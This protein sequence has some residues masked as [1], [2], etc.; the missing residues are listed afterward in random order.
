MELDI[1]ELEENYCNESERKEL[2]WNSWN[3]ARTIARDRQN[4]KDY[5]AAL[6]AT[7]P[8]EDGER[9]EMCE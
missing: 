2:G 3:G 1:P 8:E 9:Q 7:G 5:N 6:W 4:W